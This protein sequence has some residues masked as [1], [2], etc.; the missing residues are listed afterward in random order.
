MLS[1]IF[2]FMLFPVFLL[3]SGGLIAEQYLGMTSKV[4]DEKFAAKIK[5]GMKIT[6]LIKIIGVAPMPTG[7]PDRLHW[8]GCYSPH[9]KRYCYL[10]V[11]TYK[12][13]VKSAIVTTPSGRDI[14]IEG[15]Q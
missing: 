7:S 9:S 8:D 6:E 10:G 15:M 14:K 2:G 3:F 5:P 11:F 13:R 4:F 12:D 1:R